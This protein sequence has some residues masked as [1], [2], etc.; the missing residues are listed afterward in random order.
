MT[1]MTQLAHF[2]LKNRMLFANMI[3]NAV[4]VGVVLFL[5]GHTALSSFSPEAYEVIRVV[6]LIFI[7][8]AFLVPIIMVIR[9]ERPIRL[10]L[11]LEQ[12][13]REVSGEVLSRARRQLLNEPFFLIAVDFGIWLLAGI[14]YPV[15]LWTFDAPQA[16]IMR[17]FFMSLFTGLITTAVAF[18]VLEHVLQRKLMPYFFPE[19][20]LFMTPKTLRI[21][22]STRI[23]ALIFAANLVP[24]FAILHITARMLQ[25]RADS[26]QA[27]NQLLPLIFC[28]GENL[29]KKIY[30]NFDPLF[31]IREDTI[32]QIEHVLFCLLRD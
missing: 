24:F 27:L 22:I 17:P 2:S 4:G 3:S 20:G 19:G 12:T 23:G 7:P 14:V 13:G 30:D 15:A 28:R 32:R 26:V 1:N 16:I 5:T 11:N 25:D 18:F 10:Q 9:Y 29:L 8:F 21:R 31:G 6:H